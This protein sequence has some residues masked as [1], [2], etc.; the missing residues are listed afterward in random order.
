MRNCYPNVRL[1]FDSKHT[2]TMKKDALIQLEVS[3]GRKKKYISTGVKVCKGQFDL[4]HGVIK[5]NDKDGL[6]LSKIPL[7]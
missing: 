6:F 5:R 2:A 3:F 1:V 7:P 4:A